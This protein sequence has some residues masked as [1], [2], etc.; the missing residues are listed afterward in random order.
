VGTLETF[1]PAFKNSVA[2]Q[3]ELFGACNNL[4]AT[5]K[6]TVVAGLSSLCIIE[7][8]DFILIMERDQAQ[9]PEKIAALVAEHGWGNLV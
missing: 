3:L 7:L 4:I 1:I 9:N 6:K 5:Q 2:P 8:D